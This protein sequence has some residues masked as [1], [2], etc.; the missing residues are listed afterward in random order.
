MTLTSGDVG[1]VGAK[2]GV[3]HVLQIKEMSPAI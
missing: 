1:G 3:V 2:K